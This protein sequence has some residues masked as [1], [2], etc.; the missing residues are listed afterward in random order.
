MGVLAAVLDWIKGTTAEFRVTPK[1]GQ[2]G[3]LPF[4]VLLPYALLSIVS[5]LPVILLANIA[6]ATGFYFFATIN[7]L[8]YAALL[9]VIV[10]QH[11]RENPQFAREPRP[12]PVVSRSALAGAVLALG[13][14]AIPIRLPQGIDAVTVGVERIVR[15]LN[16]TRLW[17][18]S[19]DVLR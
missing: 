4:R 6:Q 14:L 1:G 7:C 11:R 9:L 12:I 19:F 17:G 2:S 13:L 16:I 18:D 5:A 3:D 15:H 8:V 10:F